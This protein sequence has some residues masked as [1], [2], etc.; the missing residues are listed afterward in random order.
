M[1]LMVLENELIIFLQER[2]SVDFGTCMLHKREGCDFV[3][4]VED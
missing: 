4:V 2:K 3:K 1:S